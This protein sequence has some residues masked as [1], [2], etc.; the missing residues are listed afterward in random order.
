MEA[1]KMNRKYN[2]NDY[3]PENVNMQHMPVEFVLD[4]SGSMS[5]FPIQMLNQ[6]VNRFSA[7]VCKDARC[8]RG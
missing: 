4:I 5:G 8:F 3:P 6:S 7:D 1:L 2:F